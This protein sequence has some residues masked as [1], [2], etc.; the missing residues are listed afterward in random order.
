MLLASTTSGSIHKAME[1]HQFERFLL[2]FKEVDRD[3][4]SF[5]EPEIQRELMRAFVIRSAFRESNSHDLSYIQQI[6]ETGQTNASV[7][8]DHSSSKTQW[9]S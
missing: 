4:T 9:T 7:P 5:S 2:T 1:E 6:P 8:Q 3:A